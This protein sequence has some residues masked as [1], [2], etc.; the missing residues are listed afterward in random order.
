[1]AKILSGGISLC[2]GLCEKEGLV[3]DYEL[4][5]EIIDYLNNEFISLDSFK[6]AKI[7]KE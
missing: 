2:V 4:M 6:D 5:Q 1:M 7:I 3:K